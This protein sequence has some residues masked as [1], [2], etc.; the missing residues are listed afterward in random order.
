MQFS[1][2]KVVP[3][4]GLIVLVFFIALSYFNNSIFLKEIL[5]CSA[6]FG[7]VLFVKMRGE[8]SRSR[9]IPQQNHY[10]DAA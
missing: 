2:S 7:M 3:F 10:S 6:I 1:K 9:S 4:L 8:V 5:V